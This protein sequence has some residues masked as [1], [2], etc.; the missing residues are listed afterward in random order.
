M[1]SSPPPLQ[2]VVF[3][4]PQ[5]NPGAPRRGVP[6]WVWWL[7]GAFLALLLLLVLA[8]GGLAS[9]GWN[10]FKT[11][12]QAALQEEPAVREWIGQIE[13]FDLDLIATGKAPGGEEFVFRVRGDRGQGTA[14]ATFV[15][16]GSDSEV[17]TDGTLRMSDGQSFPLGIDA[18]TEAE[19]ES[20]D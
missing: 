8:L 6:G 7:T 13:E 18:E 1:S 10:L 9:F 4:P 15:S 12:A 17:I 5:M 16:V 11:Q 20:L 19:Y 3:P 2:P 14:Q